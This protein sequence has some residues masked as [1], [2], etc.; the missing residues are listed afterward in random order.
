[1]VRKC[2]RPFLSSGGRS[3]STSLTSTNYVL[4]VNLVRLMVRT[5]KAS[6]PGAEPARTVIGEDTNRGELAG[7]IRAARQRAGIT[8]RELA[9]RLSVTP[10]AVGQWETD[11]VPSTER[12]TALAG[13]LDVSIDWLLGKSSQAR[14]PAEAAS[15]TDEDLR[16]IQEARRLGVNL[17][18]IVAEARQQRWL[19][20]NRGALE[21]ANAFIT[22]HGLWS[23]GKRLF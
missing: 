22:K 19:Q 21:D 17:K 16:L 20:E 5:R 18:S 2:R 6:G 15:D 23:D 9:E 8:Q 14:H 4:S 13:V 12:L 7:R 10:G 1:V 11:G 3:L